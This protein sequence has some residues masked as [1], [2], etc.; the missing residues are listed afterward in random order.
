MRAV[1]VDRG[2]ICPGT[3][4]RSLRNRFRQ[5]LPSAGQPWMSTETRCRGS[6]H[7]RAGLH[8]SVL[9]T[10]FKGDCQ[11]RLSVSIDLQEL[12]AVGNPDAACLRDDGNF[13]G[14]YRQRFCRCAVCRK[15]SD[16][17]ATGCPSS[18]RTTLNF[19][20]AGRV[21]AAFCSSAA[22]DIPTNATTHN[23]E[24]IA[25]SPRRVSAAGISRLSDI[26]SCSSD[27]SRGREV[28]GTHDV[29]YH[30]SGALRRCH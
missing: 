12:F 20:D 5:E 19:S 23:V 13:D 6:G 27:P 18:L 24:K 2:L 17:S 9:K 3:K 11:Q 14:R 7:L 21:R 26:V 4:K 16:V 22:R 8:C 28:F 25:T 1:S 29:V 10:S 15:T 30:R